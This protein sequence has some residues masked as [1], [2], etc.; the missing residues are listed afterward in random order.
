MVIL[1]RVWD[2]CFEEDIALVGAKVLLFDYSGK[3]IAETTTDDEGYYEFLSLPISRYS[4]QIIY[5]ECS[6]EE[7]SSS[8]TVI[9]SDLPSGFPTRLPSSHPSQVSSLKPSV[10]P[11][12]SPSVSPTE[13]MVIRRRVWDPCYDQEV[14]LVD[15]TVF[16]HDFAGN[17]IAE[18]TTDNEGYYEFLSLPV[19]RYS[20]EI[21]YPECASDEPSLAPSKT[22]SNTPSNIPTLVLLKLSSVRLCFSWTK[23]LP[24]NFI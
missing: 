2:P 1:R 6:S 8:P 5:P 24:F 21:I 14:A 22:Q 10:S 17:I 15:A 12:A 18:T 3:V 19:S 4:V 16:L 20:V 11:S 9:H 7:P 13:G 23:D